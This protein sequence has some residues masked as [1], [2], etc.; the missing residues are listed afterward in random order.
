MRRINLMPNHLIQGQVSRRTIWNSYRIGIVATVFV[1]WIAVACVQVKRLDGLNEIES[2]KYQV[3]SAQYEKLQSVNQERTRLISEIER[4]DSMRE[5]MPTV[6]IMALLSQGTPDSIVITRLAIRPFLN[7]KNSKN[8]RSNARKASPAT[9]YIAIEME[10]QTHTDMAITQ[11]I[12]QLGKHGVFAD[13]N[14]DKNEKVQTES[15]VVWCFQLSTKIPLTGYV[16]S[17]NRRASID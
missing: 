11:M 4:I 9:S 7:H 16:A 3:I 10:G 8:H 13:F 12:S 6:A 1:L 14:I 2:K 5:P 15:G 17:S